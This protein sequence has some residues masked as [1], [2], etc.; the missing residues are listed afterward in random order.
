MR[1]KEN[2]TMLQDKLKSPKALAITTN[3]AIRPAMITFTVTSQ[4][5][6]IFTNST[7]HSAGKS[8]MKKNGV[9]SLTVIVTFMEQNQALKTP[10]VSSSNSVVRAANRRRQ[11]MINVTRTRAG[12]QSSNMN[13]KR[14][15]AGVRPSKS[16]TRGCLED[17]RQQV[18][19]QSLIGTNSRI[20]DTKSQLMLKGGLSAKLNTKST[21]QASRATSTHRIEVTL[22]RT[23]MSHGMH[24]SGILKLK[25]LTYRTLASSENNIKTTAIMRAQNGF[26]TLKHMSQ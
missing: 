9:Q 23:L 12:T 2:S 4:V 20:I 3:L 26:S 13:R 17:T 18:L 22:R 24:F 21:S 1:I 6:K 5:K 19:N 16:T 15:G 25:C 11:I 10:K 8:Q 7:L 14:L